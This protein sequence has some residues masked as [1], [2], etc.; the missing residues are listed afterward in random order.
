MEGR[1]LVAIISDAASTGISLQVGGRGGGGRAG[2]LGGDAGPGR[3]AGQAGGLAGCARCCAGLWALSPSSPGIPVPPRLPLPPAQADRRVGN[4]RRRCHIT[5]ELPWSAD[6]AVQQV[7]ARLPAAPC[8]AAP[9]CTMCAVLTCGAVLCRTSSP[10]S[11]SPLAI[12]LPRLPLPRSFSLAA[13][14]APTRCRPRCTASSRY[15]W[16]GSTA[17]PLPQPRWAWVGSRAAWLLRRK[18]THATRHGAIAQAATQPF[19][20]R[21]APAARQCPAT[22]PPP[23]LPPRAGPPRSAWPPWAPCC[24]ATVTPSAPAPSSRA[25]TSTTRT[26]RRHCCGCCR[27]SA[28]STAASPCPGSRWGAGQGGQGGGGCC[29][30]CWHGH[31]RVRGEVASRGWQGLASAASQVLGF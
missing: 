27:T 11:P 26:A 18:R 23:V 24:A 28:G 30:G 31:G 4:Q 2:W 3:E 19:G 25:S 12:L 16:A 8:C 29:R 1:K 9:W 17:S 13:P 21:V 6:K 7:G 10:S 14:T 20:T 22:S 5:L 15:P